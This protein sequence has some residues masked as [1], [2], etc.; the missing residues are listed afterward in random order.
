MIHPFGR[1]S[2]EP[3]R[4]ARESNDRN[5]TS[6]RE[7]PFSRFGIFLSAIFLSLNNDRKQKTGR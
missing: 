4:T 1:A 7:S 3:S 6:Q 5:R 2:N